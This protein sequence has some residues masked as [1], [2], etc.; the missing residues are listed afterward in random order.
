MSHTNNTSRE[1][2][3]WK[4]ID[5][6]HAADIHPIVE[7][8]DEEYAV[9]PTSKVSGQHQAS[10]VAKEMCVCSCPTMLTVPK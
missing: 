10:G 7:D 6:E 2:N 1:E 4:M 3:E 9:R 8:N 5:F